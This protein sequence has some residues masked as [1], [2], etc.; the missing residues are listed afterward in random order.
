LKISAT[1]IT[2]NEE[3]NILA[4]CQS[5]SWADEI[6]VVDSGSTDATCEIALNAG[7]RVLSR[8]WTGFADQKQFAVDQAR[9]DWIFSLDADERVSN[10]LADSIREIISGDPAQAADGYRIPRRSFY[11]GRWIKAGGWY[12]DYQLRFFNRTRG[13]W[14]GAYVHESFAM[15]PGSRVEILSG[16]ILH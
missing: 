8:T 5:L 7:A 9:N 12:P 15:L 10:R 1:I 16:D 3:E 11:M 14:K 2:L 6:V 4:A 13:A